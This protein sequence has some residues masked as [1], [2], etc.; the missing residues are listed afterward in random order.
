MYYSS[1][2]VNIELGNTVSR[3]TGDVP[4]GLLEEVCNQHLPGL[5][6]ARRQGVVRTFDAGLGVVLTGLVPR[7]RE[8]LAGLGIVA[9]T[10]DH[11]PL[12]RRT[13]GW[14]LQ[15]SIALRDYQQACVDAALQHDNGIL[16]A[17]TGAGKT[18]MGAAII[19]RLGVPTLWVTTSRVLLDQARDDL[20]RFLG[21][22]P[23]VCGGGRW[24]VDDL[25]VALVQALDRRPAAIPAGRFGLLIF[26]E[27]HHAAARTCCATCLRVDARRNYFLT[28]VPEREGEDQVV[29]DALT[30]GVVAAA[31]ARELVARRWLCP[32]EARFTTVV[33]GGAMTELR[34][35][36]VYR[37][38]I[39]ENEARNALVAADARTQG[40]AGES[41]LVLVSQVAHGERLR[42]LLPDAALVHGGVPRRALRR[43]VDDFAA[44]RRRLLI[45]TTGL[46]A[47]GVNIEGTSCIVY[48][49]GLRSRTRTL[50][51]VGRG[52]RLAPGKTRC[53]YQD[54]LD[55]DDLGRLLAHA[56]R[57]R[58]V[59]V[60]A[61]FIASVPVPVRMP[62]ELTPTWTRL[63]DGHRLALVAPSGEIRARADC[64]RPE[65]VPRHL[66]A[67]CPKRICQA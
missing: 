33:I 47:E 45:A 15:P 36:T 61:G 67:R 40:R 8:R 52:L 28:A 30:G 65:T 56:R 1:R 48:A 51:A 54:Y 3:V 64:R 31:P 19:A 60:E 12:M 43:M 46:F 53:L 59:L 25:T 37:R 42:D 49:A 27:G 50:Q 14:S 44:G 17:G 10:S 11:R 5:W 2:C 6:R 23:A 20:A 66:C 41:V 26:D 63:P 24:Q 9:T 22:V 62:R 4:V 57:R 34:F 13:C 7:L 21:A 32:V 55:Q 29:L 16:A 35:A 58:E 38:F 39:V 18:L